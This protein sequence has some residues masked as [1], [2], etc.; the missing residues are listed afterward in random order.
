MGGS[1]EL[2]GP[3]RDRRGS[4]SDGASRLYDGGISATWRLAPVE[5]DALIADTHDAISSQITPVVINR[6]ALAV[7]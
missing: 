1:L 7:T 4:P 6:L 3:L 2:A 5:T